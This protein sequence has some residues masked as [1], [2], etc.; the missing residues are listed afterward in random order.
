MFYG[1]AKRVQKNRS[2]Q[3]DTSWDAVAGWYD[4]MVGG[5]GSRYHRFVALPTTLA[6]LEPQPGERILDLGAG[7]GV[8]APSVRKAGA[9]YTGVDLSPRLVKHARRRHGERGTFLVGDVRRLEALRGLE[10]GSFDAGVFLLSLQDMDPLDE[11]IASASW[12]LKPKARLVLFMLHPCFRVPRGS[13]WGED[14]KR[15]LHYRRVDR[16]LSALAVPMKAHKGGS[17]RSFHRPLQSYVKA[18]G[19]EGFTVDRLMELPDD[20]RA[21][22]R[23]D[24]NTDIPLFLALRAV[25]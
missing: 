23:E 16:Y 11:V 5:S 19:R 15:K 9:T 8:L 1:K 2:R 25:R 14:E 10:A 21:R 6:L 3:K 4:G 20:P 22:A 12:A 7:Q 17:T 13:G 24:V 18:L